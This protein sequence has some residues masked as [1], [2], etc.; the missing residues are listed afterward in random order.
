MFE[1]IFHTYFKFELVCLFAYYLLLVQLRTDLCQQKVCIA[2][3]PRVNILQI[4]KG[5]DLPKNWTF[6]KVRI[7]F[8]AFQSGKMSQSPQ[9]GKMSGFTRTMAIQTISY[10]TL[11][12]ISRP[13]L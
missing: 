12:H 10:L 8:I 2:N 6:Y 7:H 5:L 3:K 4:T 13:Y 9:T 1:D 11:N